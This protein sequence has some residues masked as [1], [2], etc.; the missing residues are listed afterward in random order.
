MVNKQNKNLTDREKSILETHGWLSA[1]PH[2]FRTAVL[3][4]AEL[5]TFG[6]GES[7]YRLEDAPGGLYAVCD[8]FI[9][10]I[11]ALQP[12]LPQLVHVA[13][14]GWWVGDAALITDTPRRA[15]LTTRT[16]ATIAYV[17]KASLLDICATEP[18]G[19]RMVA[20]LSVGMFDHTLAMMSAYRLD[21]AEARI[22]AV[23]RALL[24]EGQIFGHADESDPVVF[25]LS[26]LDVADLTGLSRNATGPVLRR[27]QRRGAVKLGYRQFSIVD[28]SLL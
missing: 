7:I 22:V 1:Q 20:R 4:E 15:A 5:L 18:E 12:D 17:P 27:L 28:R 11:I 19:W 24:G 23:L 9:D 14:Q 10:V 2:R 8:G 26:Q 6:P 21:T 25:P 3:S 13:R 16:A